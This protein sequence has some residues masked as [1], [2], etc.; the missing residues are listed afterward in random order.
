MGWALPALGASLPPGD[1]CQLSSPFKEGLDRSCCQKASCTNAH[2]HQILNGPL[3]SPLIGYKQQGSCPS[4]SNAD[5]DIVAWG[6]LM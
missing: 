5:K 4:D 6:T 3:Q 1:A 2:A